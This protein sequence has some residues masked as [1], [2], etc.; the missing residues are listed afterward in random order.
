MNIQVK[1]IKFSHNPFSM[2][3]GNIKELNFFA[4]NC[5][6]LNSEEFSYKKTPNY[7]VMKAIYM[8]C[9]IPLVFK[10]IKYNNIFHLDGALSTPFPMYEFLKDNSGCDLD[11]IFGIDISFDQSYNFFAVNILFGI[12]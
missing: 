7:S 4:T 6:N 12:T 2:P 1:K 11:E 3:Q 8:S 5:N 10:P 9:S